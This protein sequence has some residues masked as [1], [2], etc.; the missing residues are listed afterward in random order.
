MAKIKLAARAATVAGSALLLLGVA[1]A[2]AYAATL[3]TTGA[4]GRY[5]YFK[6]GT[7]QMWLTDTL[8][9][10]HCAQWQ[11]KASGGSWTWVGERNCSSGEI[12]AVWLGRLGYQIRICR[13]GVGNCSTAVKL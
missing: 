11:E 10:G 6:N 1:A 5:E 8:S 9:D 13:T 3:S 7:Y 4:K 12:N 2:P